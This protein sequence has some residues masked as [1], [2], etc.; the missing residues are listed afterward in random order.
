MYM[1]DIIGVIRENKSSWET[2]I[3]ENEGNLN[4][5]GDITGRPYVYGINIDGLF[6]GTLHDIRSQQDSLKAVIRQGETDRSVLGGRI[7]SLQA[8]IVKQQIRLASTLESYQTDLQSRKEAL[9]K[10]RRELNVDLKKQTILDA[11]NQALTRFDRKEA[12]IFREDN[13]IRIRLVGLTFDSGKTTIPS[14]K[15]PLLDKMEKYLSLYQNTKI[16]VEGHTDATGK[17]A[18]NLSYSEARANSVRDYLLQIG[19]VSEDNI[20]AL[21][22]GSSVPVASNKTRSE[23]AQNRRIVVIVE[24]DSVEMG[25]K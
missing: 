4:R 17:E 11:A 19:N 5:V 9:E 23:R 7:D 22:L 15:Y 18:K 3:L 12:L 24:F 13:V 8:A 10:R 25:L 21:G 2:L 14:E 16:I 1:L 6:E 20:A